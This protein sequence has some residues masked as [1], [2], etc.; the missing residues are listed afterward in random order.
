MTRRRYLGTLVFAAVAIWF[1]W[2]R[3]GEPVRFLDS[4]EY[5]QWPL[6]RYR[7]GLLYFG[8]RAISYPALLSLVGSGIALVHLQTWLSVMSW[9]GLGWVL[10]RAPGAVLALLFAYSSPLRLWNHTVLT[11]SLTLSFLALLIAFGVLLCRRWSNPLFLAWAL[12]LAYF[13]LLRDSNLILIPFLVA[14]LIL[15]GRRRMITACAVAAIV[16]L[17]GAWDANRQQRWKPGCY[18]AFM[19]RVITDPSAKQYFE[20]RG[21]PDNPFHADHR[22]FLEWLGKDGRRHYA[23]WVVSKADSYVRPW[24]YLFLGGGNIGRP[25]TPLVDA[26]F[27]KF[28]KDREWPRSASVMLADGLFTWAALPL[29]LSV[30]FLVPLVVDAVR[31]RAFGIDASWIG[32]LAVAVVVSTFLSYHASGDSSARHVLASSVLYRILPLW[33]LAALVRSARR[34]RTP[35]AET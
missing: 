11:E 20:D 13:G 19:T 22:E 7:V 31:F 25:K 5:L 21:M 6:P 34:H 26:L 33:T 35:T 16:M 30:V 32:V 1:F 3:L 15:C 18:T 27:D 4:Y 14:P 28:W 2:P 17:A 8:S 23:R 9:G 29:A 12:S 24:E 10:G